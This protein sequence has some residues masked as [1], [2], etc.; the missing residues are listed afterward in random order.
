MLII[1]NLIFY[2]TNCP[3]PK[4][5]QI[6]I[7]HSNKAA[8][9]QIWDAE[10]N[11]CSVW[12]SKEPWVKIHP[13]SVG[14]L[15]NHFILHNHPYSSIYPLIFIVSECLLLLSGSKWIFKYYSEF[16]GEKN[17]MWGYLQSIWKSNRIFILTAQ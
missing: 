15:L 5:I 7:R 12:L 9:H 11:K 10:I 2:Q 17:V 4:T 14:D 8:Y 3:K 13:V 1:S 6:I 16:W